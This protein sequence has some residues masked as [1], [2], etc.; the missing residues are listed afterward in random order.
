VV[1]AAGRL[2][3]EIIPAFIAHLR[4]TLADGAERHHRRGSGILFDFW[5]TNIGTHIDG[6]LLTQQMHRRGINA[7]YLSTIYTALTT[8]SDSG[9]KTHA[10]PHARTHAR[11]I[12]PIPHAH[13]ALTFAF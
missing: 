8:T 6:E 9:N 13:N 7:R 5:P 11:T 2:T 3:S 10:R 12:A 4:E 1:E